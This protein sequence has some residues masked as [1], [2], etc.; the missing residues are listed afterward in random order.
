MTGNALTI[1]VQD[2]LFYEIRT[3]GAI[4]LSRS[5]RTLV[6]YAVHLQPDAEHSVCMARINTPTPQVF[7]F[8]VFDDIIFKTIREPPGRIYPV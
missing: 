3:T 4:S 7:H 6:L 1:A 5:Q 2:R 8:M